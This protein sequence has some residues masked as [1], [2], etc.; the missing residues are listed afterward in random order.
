MV[1]LS[2]SQG[3]RVALVRWSQSFSADCNT[4]GGSGPSGPCA[5]AV[6]HSGTSSAGTAT[7]P[8]LLQK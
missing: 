2:F 8:E 3:E 5:E 4:D 1:T 6:R 7:L